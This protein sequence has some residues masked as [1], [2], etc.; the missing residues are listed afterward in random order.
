MKSLKKIL[1]FVRAKISRFLKPHE[2]YWLAT[3]SKEP[4]STKY[5]FDRG[6]P[7]DRY[8]IED[9][10][11]INEKDIKGH[12][13]EITDDSYTKKF[14]GDKVKDIDV[15]DINKKNKKANIY[16]DLRDLKGIVAD[17]TYDCI[18]LTHVLGLIDEVDKAVVEAKRILKPGGVILATSSSFSP[19][20]DNKYNYWSFKPAGFKY[21]FS[22]HFKKNKIKV[23]SYGN[24]LAGQ[25][26]WVGMSQED[27]SKDA[28]KFNDDRFPCI[29]AARV[30][31]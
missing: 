17:D 26:F 14:G 21:L 3:K 25:C 11:K 29:V 16:G 10:L 18:L 19:V 6:T 23:T 24:V 31:K 27:I 20:I 2:H 22:K 13:L 8:W 7:I 9:F 28:L 15:L 30:Q 5:G 12:C 4:I 1:F